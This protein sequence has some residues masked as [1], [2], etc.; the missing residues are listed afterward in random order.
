MV[1]EN[2]M[3]LKDFEE[4]V[5]R[6]NEFNRQRQ[7][8]TRII[9]DLINRVWEAV[10]WATVEPMKQVDIFSVDL[11]IGKITFR[12]VVVSDIVGTFRKRNR[13]SHSIGVTFAAEG[14]EWELGENGV[15]LLPVRFIQGL[16]GSLP[17]IAD[18]AHDTFPNAGIVQYF[19]SFPIGIW[20]NNI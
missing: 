20:P 11:L 16:Y 4:Y 15:N 2:K 10:D 8:A 5:A 6:S 17:V 1:V 9:K 14:H 3:T 7:M 12:A 13:I 18:K 19:K